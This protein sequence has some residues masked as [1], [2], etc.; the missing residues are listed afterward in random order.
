MKSETTRSKIAAEGAL[1]MLH[2]C[3][4]SNDYQTAVKAII[5]CQLVLCADLESELNDRKSLA[6]THVSALQKDTCDIRNKVEEI[7]N[8]ANKLWD[9]SGMMPDEHISS[10][11]K[12][13]DLSGGPKD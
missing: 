10:L 11:S 9:W 7:N 5:R 2:A 8:L 13:I 1:K 4:N 6:E 12:I 3:K